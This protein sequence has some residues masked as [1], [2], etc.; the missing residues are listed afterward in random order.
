MK[1]SYVGK[2]A[3]PEALKSYRTRTRVI[4]AVTSTALAFALGGS[5]KQDTAPQASHQD[6]KKSV[7]EMS[8]AEANNASV[9]NESGQEAVAVRLDCVDQDKVNKKGAVV[10]NIVATHEGAAGGKR[11]HDHSVLEAS[12]RETMDGYAVEYEGESHEWVKLVDHSQASSFDGMPVV[13]ILSPQQDKYIN[14]AYVV[15][16]QT[17][18]ECGFE[19]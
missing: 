1:E 4:G 15:G 8:C 12:C 11:V 19:A 14:G 9:R 18:P 2:H 7:F 6:V 3:T 10:L 16:E 17:L 5:S 13:D